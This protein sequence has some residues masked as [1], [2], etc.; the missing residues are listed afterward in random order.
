MNLKALG[1]GLLLLVLLGCASL[2]RDDPIDIYQ[3][4]QSYKKSSFDEVWSAALQSIDEID[5]VVRKATKE[6]G[7][8]HALAKMN[9]NPSY[10]PP[11][12]NV[13]IRKENGRID[14]NFHLELPGQRD[15][16]GIRRSY[17]NQFFKAL[18]R[19]LD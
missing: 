17:A 14:V 3:K 11:Q 2:H 4:T 16:S 13:I 9:P 8:I 7:F 19:N 12:M 1:L 18:K 10:L 6:I 5:F 15:E